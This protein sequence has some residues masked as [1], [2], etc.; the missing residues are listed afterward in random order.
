MS[1]YQHK[2]DSGSLFKND[3]REKDTQ[4]HYRGD[5]LVDGKEYWVS[6][7]VNEGKNGKY[8][9]LKFSEKQE[10]HD[11]GMAKARDAAEPDDFVDEDLPF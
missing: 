10:A 11:K 6:A 3:R 7:W 4:P 2:P 8:F 9:S 1:D 5:C